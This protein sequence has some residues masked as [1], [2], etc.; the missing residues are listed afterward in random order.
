VQELQGLVARC[1]ALPVLLPHLPQEPALCEQVTALTVV[2]LRLKVVQDCL[3]F[4]VRCLL[5]VAPAKLEM[6]DMCSSQLDQVQQNLV[7]NCI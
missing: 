7:D 3:G 4:R 6:L 2:L 1:R 5:Q